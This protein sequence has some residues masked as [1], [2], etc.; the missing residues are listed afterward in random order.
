MNLV[1]FKVFTDLGNL[2]EGFATPWYKDGAFN[3][4]E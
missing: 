3:G 4:N 2:L 1:S